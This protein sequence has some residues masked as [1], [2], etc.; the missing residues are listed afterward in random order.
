MTIR[1]TNSAIAHL[2]AI[3]EHIGCDSPRYASRM[4][5][6]ITAR[7]RQVGT[8][9]LSDQSVPEYRDP[10]IREVIE[11]PDRMIYEVADNDIRALS[12]IHGARLPPPQP[13]RAE[14]VGQSDA[15]GP[16]TKQAATPPGVPAGRGRSPRTI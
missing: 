15:V 4:V 2:V 10:A 13:P 9:P 14:N 12:V 6:R 8:F 1:W 16:L 7:T 3:H 5:D 11:G